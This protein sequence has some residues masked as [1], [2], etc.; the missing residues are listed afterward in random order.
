MKLSITTDKLKAE[1]KRAIA[2]TGGRTTLPILAN[3]KI[4]AD[5][6]KGTVGLYAT[7]LDAEF[8]VLFE[9]QVDE[10]GETTINAKHLQQIL[11]NIKV[12]DITLSCE[13]ENPNTTVK[14]G[15]SS[16]LLLGLPTKEYPEFLIQGD[17]IAE[18]DL[19][20]REFFSLLKSVKFSMAYDN[21]KVFMNGV[22]FIID[23]EDG[24]VVAEA[25]NAYILTKSK[26][27]VPERGKAKMDFILPARFADFFDESVFSEDDKFK[28]IQYN[29]CISF[30]GKDVMISTKVVDAKY[31]ETN[32][33]VPKVDSFHKIPLNRKEFL[34]K[35]NLIRSFCD[36]TS[37]AVYIR[38]NRNFLK[39][40]L[41]SASKGAVDDII[42]FDNP[43][44]SVKEDE[45]VV[46]KINSIYTY[47]ILKSGKSVEITLMLKNSTTPLVFRENGVETF[48][49]LMPMGSK[50]KEATPAANAPATPPPSQPV[51]SA[52][53]KK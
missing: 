36:D 52:E 3:I 14:Y 38:L 11:D 48:S 50:K 51:A 27:E 26:L 30:I 41:E 21:A 8:S 28:I 44:E 17:K 43:I 47:M 6:D 24:K 37:P 33:F 34:D 46:A 12:P 4:V 15:K 18:V 40:T 29:N 23:M 2:F 7:N 25:T 20:V 16:V 45:T 5:A 49:V 42:E 9:A 13:A 31:P 10:S 19:E 22:H 39:F 1:L 35:I 32:K 53:E